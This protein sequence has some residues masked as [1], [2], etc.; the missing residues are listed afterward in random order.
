MENIFT[1]VI[2]A[3]VAGAVGWLGQKLLLKYWPRTRK[4]CMNLESVDCPQC[5]E[6][7]PKIRKPKKSRQLLWGGWTCSKCGIE[8]DKYGDRINS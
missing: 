3:L 5:G 8:M 4:M 2:G 6:P 7:A 1:L